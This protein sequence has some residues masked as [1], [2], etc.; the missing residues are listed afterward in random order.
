MKV[1]L[2]K[3]E[4]LEVSYNGVVYILMGNPEGKPQLVFSHREQET[5]NNE[6]YDNQEQK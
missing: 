2:E 6:Q 1:T 4:M 3:N 5:P